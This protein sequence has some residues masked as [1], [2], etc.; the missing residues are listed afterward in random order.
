MTSSPQT[1]QYLRALKLSAMLATVEARVAQAED[2]KLRYDEFL[3]L[4]LE[5]ELAR[6]ATMSLGARLQ[7]AGVQASVAPEGE[8]DVSTMRARL[9]ADEE[10]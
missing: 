5:D 9:L 7:R 6:R 1:R 8:T 3:E 4:L 10:E 2:M